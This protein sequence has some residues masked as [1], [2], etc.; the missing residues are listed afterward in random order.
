MTA[1]EDALRTVIARHLPWGVD[2]HD[3][4][5]QFLGTGAVREQ[6]WKLHVS[7]TPFSAGAVFEAAIAVLF[8]EGARFKVVNSIECMFAFNGGEFGLSQIGKFLTVY[9]SDDDH[10]VRLARRLD[11]ATRGLAGPRIPSDRRLNPH[12]LVHYRYGAMHPRADAD[13]DNATGAYDLVDS[14]GRLTQDVRLSYYL[15]PTG[16][17]DPIEAAGL[18]TSQ[19]ARNIMLN[20]RFLVIDAL[21]ISPRGNV[22]RAVDLGTRPARICVLKEFWRDVCHD[23]WGRDAQDWARNE[24]EILTRLADDSSVPRLLDSFDIDGDLYSAIEFIDGCPLED[25]I[26]ETADGKNSYADVVQVGLATAKQLIQ[27]HDRNIVYRD[28]KPAN[29]IRTPDGGYRLVDFGIAFETRGTGRPLGLGTPVY[30]APEQ[31]EGHYP[32]V[33]ADIFAW[34]AVLHRLCCGASAIDDSAERPYRRFG[35]RELEPEV[36]AGLADVIDRALAWDPT[37]R[38]PKMSHA[39]DA[40]RQATRG[41]GKQIRCA[42]HEPVEPVRV[43]DANTAMVHAREIGDSLCEQAQQRSDGWFWPLT[44]RRRTGSWPLPDLYSGSAGIALLLAELSR[45]TGEQR[46]AEAARAAA[47]WLAGPVWARGWAQHG[48]HGGEPGIAFLFVRLADLLDEPGYRTAADLRLRR[49]CGA[50]A[51]TEDLLYGTAGT[52]VALLRVYTATGE[53]RHLK[54]ARRFGDAL[55]AAARP[56]PPDGAGR[57]WDVAPAEPDGSPRPHLGLLHGAAGIALALTELAAATAEQRYLDV[58]AAVAELLI[59]QGRRSSSKTGPVGPGVIWSRTLTDN[60]TATQAHCHGAGGIGQFFVRL[61]QLVPDPRYRDV[62][63]GAAA[64]TTASLRRESQLGICHGVSGTGQ[65]LL[66]CYRGL[67]TADSLAGARECAA[68]IDRFRSPDRP[69]SYHTRG[70]GRVGPEL[71]LGS[72]GIAAFML[73][74]TD[75]DNRGEIVLG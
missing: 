39:R 58:A 60:D 54:H 65:L 48:L 40:L 66:D 34:G 45:A 6:G 4:C 51:A 73:R 70:D 36:P 41:V 31:Y 9:P 29:I 7:A 24:R 53:T 1:P 75:P 12:S 8:D 37:D 68:V 42:V 50:S 21:S 26:G 59:S 15:P 74:L 67:G 23:P 71:M 16:I 61:H 44:T 11:Q 38:F 19:S 52:L 3:H 22:F 57:Y 43:I 32:D 28:F 20:G 33:T 69:G 17:P 30:C 27:L 63:L 35:V 47:G 49:F 10:C 55:V 72:A 5:Y 56:G 13:A 64:T 14:A 2:D 62:A 46:Y 25:V 18:V